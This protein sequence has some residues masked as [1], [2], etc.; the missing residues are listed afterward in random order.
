ML[1]YDE[2]KNKLKLQAALKALAP[3]HNS[4]CAA[5]MGAWRRLLHSTN[6]AAVEFQ[7]SPLRETVSNMSNDLR[8]CRVLVWREAFKIWNKSDL[9]DG[10]CT[11]FFI[12]GQS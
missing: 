10:S 3:Q 12:N 6:V 8:S 4:A 11:Q 5:T 2:N 7:M 9:P 1:D